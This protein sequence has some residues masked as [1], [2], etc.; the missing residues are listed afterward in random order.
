MRIS[1]GCLLTLTLLFSQIFNSAWAGSAQETGSQFAPEVIAK[2]A[3]D[4][5]KYAAAKGARAFIIGRVGRPVEELPKGV[6][7]TH[8]A[9]AVYSNIQLDNGEQAYGYA[10]HNLYQKSGNLGRSE[11]VTDYPLDFFWSAKQLKAG[12]IIP[13]QDLQTRLIQAIND[14]K[15][16]RIHNAN[17]SVVANPFNA[18]YQNCTEHTLDLINAAI[19]QTD[20][21]N[22]LKAAARKHFKPQTMDVSFTEVYLGSLF[23]DGVHADDHSDKVATTTFSS[24]ARYLNSNNLLDSAVA[25]APNGVDTPILLHADRTY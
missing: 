20:N 25:Y 1:T 6:D 22:Y 10:I 15:H 16:F 12:I 7:F 19:Y 3:K 4:V 2:F 5:E 18:H 17:Y 13:N 24:L 11:L 8:T 9:V 21:V 23:M 14:K